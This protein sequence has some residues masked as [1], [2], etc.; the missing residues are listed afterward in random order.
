VR[1]VPPSTV[2]REEIDRLLSRGLD[3][4]ANLLSELAELGLRYLVQQGLEQEQQDFLGRGHY[5]RRSETQRR[6]YRNG[7]EDAR[8][9]TAE[10]AV[11]VKLPQVRDATEPYRSRLMEFLDGNSDVLERLVIEMY[12]RGLSTRDVEDCFRDATGQLLISK[13]AVSEIT[14]Q[15]WDDYNAFRTRDLSDV[16]ISYL[17]LDGI[18]ESLRRYG[19]KE[20]ILCAWSITSDGRK[21]LL[22]LAVG[23]KESE[24][25]WTEF[26]RDMVGRGLKIPTSVTCDGAPGL[27]NAVPKVFSKSLRIRCWYHKTGNIRSKLPAEGAEEVL[28]HVRAV[29]DAPT[30]EAGEEAAAAV[31]ARFRERY[32]AAMACLADDLEASLNHLKVPVRHRINVRTTNLLER[33][34]EEERRRSKVIPRFGDEKSAMK[35]VFATLMRVSDR[36]NR[37]SVSEIERQQLRLLRQ[38]LGIDPPPEGVPTRVRRRKK[39]A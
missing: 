30:L 12:A 22:H 25:C 21:I 26:L 9:K 35:L 39:A 36:W 1:R 31:I 29:R 4:E 6:G 18:Y 27:L 13:S 3:Q 34:F 15:L 5:E 14:D 20:G 32:P 38:Q 2:V 24:A 10:G 37:V 11:P 33:T 7:Y 17:F 16:D 23:N 28:A 19:A 8:L